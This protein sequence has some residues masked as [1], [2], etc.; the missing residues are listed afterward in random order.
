MGVSQNE[1]YPFGGLNNK[2]NSML[3]SILGSRYF[4]KLPHAPNL[5]AYVGFG[6]QERHADV[7]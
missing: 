4:W 5:T 3:G 2:D 7:A 6:R 1:G